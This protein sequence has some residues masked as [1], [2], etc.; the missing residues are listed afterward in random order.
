MGL[1]PTTTHKFFGRNLCFK[2]VFYQLN[3]RVILP[4]AAP[5]REMTNDTGVV[6]NSRFF[7]MA[8]NVSLRCRTQ[9]Q[10]CL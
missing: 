3:Y 10:S 5:A 9:A 2:E 7:V 6:Q 1:E 4:K 8:Y